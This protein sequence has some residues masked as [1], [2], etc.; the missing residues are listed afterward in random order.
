LDKTALFSH[1][2]GVERQP[3]REEGNIDIIVFPHG[4]FW[5]IPFRGEVNS[6]GVVC[7]SAW[8]RTRRPGEPLDQFFDRTVDD[9][10]WAKRL[11]CRATRLNPVRAIAD[12]S[13][14]VEQYGGDGWLA[15][16]DSSGFVDPLFSTGAH[17]AFSSAALAADE[18]TAAL[19]AGDVS[20][21]RWQAY[22]A[23]V[24]RGVELFVGAVQAFYAGAL[25]DAIFEQPQRK[26]L[27]QTITSM[28][29]GD[30][31][32]DA[33]WTRFLRERYPVRLADHDE[34]PAAVDGG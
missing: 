1:F 27:R 10:Y 19:H 8:I 21:R 9:A 5:N 33:S 26:V 28:L 7:S 2:T 4:W 17:L 15:V 25:S 20:A 16:G 22:Q 23:T 24:R 6:F 32:G 14:R 18:I 13:Y 29:A 11:L 12:Y 31:F 30:V 3:G 34:S